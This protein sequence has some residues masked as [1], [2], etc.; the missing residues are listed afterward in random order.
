M[1]KLRS[2]V[3]LWGVWVVE[4]DLRLS[5][6]SRPP[7]PAE[8]C[9][10]GNDC[11]LWRAVPKEISR[12]CS[13]SFQRFET[14]KSEEN[15]SSP[16]VGFSLF[17]V[18][19]C[20]EEWRSECFRLPNGN[21][22]FRLCLCFW[23][24]WGDTGYPDTGIISSPVC[25]WVSGGGQGLRDAADRTADQTLQSRGELNCLSGHNPSNSVSFVF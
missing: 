3:E 22:R 5:L 2:K 18:Q 7:P 21:S 25:C 24:K 10:K 1:E 6:T 20:P 23:P 14:P 11:C 17:S 8:K 16:K 13:F 9:P 19:I 15:S 4:T 12:E